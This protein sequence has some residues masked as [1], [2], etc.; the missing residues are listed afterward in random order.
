MRLEWGAARRGAAGAGYA[1]AARAAS[2]SFLWRQAY[3]TPRSL[4]T[5]KLA[6]RLGEELPAHMMPSFVTALDE[7][8][9]LFIGDS[10]DRGALP[11]PDWGA[12]DVVYTAPV[13]GLEAQLQA[14]FQEVLGRARVGTQADFFT[15]GGNDVMARPFPPFLP[16]FEAVHKP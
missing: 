8:P 1:P 10:V 13:N 11:L 16:F 6:A 12:A 5:G 9:L 14:V 2:W 7:M 3:V 4:D 15:M